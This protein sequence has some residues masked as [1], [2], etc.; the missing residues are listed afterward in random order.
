RLRRARD[1]WIARRHARRARRSPAGDARRGRRARLAR[2][3]RGRRAR[4]VSGF[5]GGPCVAGNSRVTKNRR[6]A[7][8]VRGMGRRLASLG[9]LARALGALALLCHSRA[10]ELRRVL[11]LVPLRMLLALTGLHLITLVAR[12][13]AWRLTLAAVEGRIPPRHAVHGANAGAF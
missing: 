4:G 8:T 1:G 2:G 12:S 5:R 9:G 6:F 10:D 3:R 13:E 11:A 7:A